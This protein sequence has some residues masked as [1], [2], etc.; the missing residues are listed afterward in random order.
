MGFSTLHPLLW[1]KTQMCRQNKAL[2]D[3]TIHMYVCIHYK[4]IP[5]SQPILLSPADGTKWGTSIFPAKGKFVFVSVCILL[6]FSSTSLGKFKF[7]CISDS[8][9]S[10]LF[11]LFIILFYFF[12]FSFVSHFNIPK[13]RKC[14]S[15]KEK[16]NERIKIKLLF[17][18]C[19]FHSFSIFHHI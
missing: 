6:G 8:F 9:F 17:S 1:I 12:I 13:T 5:F 16:V 11:F 7:K 19:F 14:E 15:K 2:A 3:C 4:Y 18:F 10:Q